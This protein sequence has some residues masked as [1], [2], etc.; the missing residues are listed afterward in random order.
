MTEYIGQSFNY[1][2]RERG[3]SINTGSIKSITVWRV[4]YVK[5]VK[6]VNAATRCRGIDNIFVGWV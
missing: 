4:I 5:I 1:T 3:Q 2:V 6:R